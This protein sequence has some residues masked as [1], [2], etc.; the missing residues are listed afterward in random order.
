[1]HFMIY[2]KTWKCEV[3]KKKKKK[4]LQQRFINFVKLKFKRFQPTTHT[5]DFRLISDKEK[6][7]LITV[8]CSGRN[9]Q[10]HFLDWISQ[11]QL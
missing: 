11:S 6:I 9:S 8:V 1:M 4:F 3:K 7:R 10:Q 5:R 2:L